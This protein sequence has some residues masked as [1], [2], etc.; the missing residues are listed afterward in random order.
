MLKSEHDKRTLSWSPDGRFLLYQ[1]YDLKTKFDLWILPHP[2]GVSGWGKPSLFQGTAAF[3]MLGRFS[4]DG[5]WIA[6]ES[7]ETGR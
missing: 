6:Y 2:G 4:P 7:N 3:E 1:V 5:R